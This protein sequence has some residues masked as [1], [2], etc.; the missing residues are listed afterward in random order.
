MSKST[1]P[2]TEE[3]FKLDV[4]TMNK[5]TQVLPAYTKYHQGPPPGTPATGDTA[6]QGAAPTEIET[7]YQHAPWGATDRMPTTLRL[8]LAK[9]SIA[10]RTINQLVQMMYGNGLVYVRNSD[11][12]ADRAALK[13]AYI[14][15]VEDWLIRNRIHTHWLPAQFVDFRHTLATFSEIIF[16]QDF[17]L[18]TGLY[19][20]PAEHC[21]LSKQNEKTNYS[22]WL[23]YSPDYSYKVTT[24]SDRI[25]RIP[26]YCWQDPESFFSQLRGRKM[27][28]YSHMYTAGMNYYPDPFW[29]GLFRDDGWIDSAIQVPEVV[30]ALMRNQATLKYQILIPES[31]FKIRNPQWE[32]YSAQARADLIDAKVREL[33]AALSGTDN[34]FLSIS[35]VFREG[36]N[37]DAQ[38]KIEIIALDD[39]LKNDNWVPSSEAADGQIVQGLGLHPSQVGLAPEGGKMGAGSGS[40]K[41]QTYNIGITLNTIEQNIILELLN[42]VARWNAATNPN[43]D[44][45]FFINHDTLTTTNQ[46]ESGVK[47]SEFSTQI[48]S[49]NP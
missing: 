25:T 19:H 33:N 2:T 30:N 7:G 34:A 35:T 21:R 26:L 10:G 11:Y 3:V 39:K 8:K 18:I 28:W 24:S 22:D 45:R 17:S 48:Q 36:L 9:V 47:P 16:S 27:A 38:G 5:R 12:A 31:Y 37:G 6:T 14:P 43:W 41:M 44:I 13:P 20:K 23:L 1:T 15:E 49:P 32:T 29:M 46:Q 40:D 4:I 42:W